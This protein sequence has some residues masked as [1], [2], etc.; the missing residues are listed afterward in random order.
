MTRPKILSANDPKAIEEAVN[1]LNSDSLI[2]FPTDTLYGLACLA[3]SET[4]L[5]K[6]YESKHRSSNKAILVLIANEAQLTMVAKNISPN[7]KKLISAFWPGKLTLILNKK[8]TLPQLLSPFESIA[9]RMP[10]HPFAHQLLITTGPLS[11]T[12]ANISEHENHAKPQEILTELGKDIS[13]FIDGGTLESTTA[14][15]I[16]DCCHEPPV[17][18]RE[19]RISQADIQRILEQ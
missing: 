17:I 3:H 19:G 10:A 14:S 1:L 4:A 15:T 18:L 8:E 5:K 9:V 16:V 11:V 7:A 6:I 12:S 2:V 13:L